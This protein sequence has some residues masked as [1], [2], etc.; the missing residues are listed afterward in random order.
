[1]TS[2]LLTAFEPYG[3]WSSNASWLTLVELT[4]SLPSSIKLTTRL[5]PVDYAQTQVLIQEELAA[6]HDVAIHLGQ[7]PGRAKISLEQVALNCA[8]TGG[9]HFRP[10]I[11]DAP[12]AYFS[13]LPL[14][15]WSATLKRNGLPS[16]VSFHAGTFLCN[17]IFYYSS[18][19]AITMGLKTESF[20][21]HL[22]LDVSQIVDD[23]DSHMPSLPVQQSAVALRLILDEI[24]HG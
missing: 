19:Y 18:H 22:P 10:L 14:S 23:P 7:A 9:G 2:V 5:F 20:F 16:E 6:N 8:E 24:A 3:R 11:S 15:D 12:A 17:A 13:P 4:K 1:M 21:L